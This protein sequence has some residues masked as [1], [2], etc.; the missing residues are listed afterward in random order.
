MGVRKGYIE[1]K[2]GLH[3]EDF[4][5]ANKLE[6]CKKGATSS[7]RLM[8]TITCKKDFKKIKTSN[9]AVKIGG[10]VKKADY[11]QVINKEKWIILMNTWNR[12]R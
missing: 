5:G 8:H 2:P 6:S 3:Q 9:V 7:R 10:G 12:R 1:H 4:S 11:F